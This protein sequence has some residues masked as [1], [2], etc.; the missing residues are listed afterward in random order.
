MTTTKSP[1]LAH[2]EVPVLEDLGG[3]RIECP[4]C[5]EEVAAGALR[6][7]HCGE[8]PRPPAVRRRRGAVV[9]WVC[10]L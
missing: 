6:C 5:A 4:A 8:R 9:G 10:L 1:T 3:I 2:D 7:P